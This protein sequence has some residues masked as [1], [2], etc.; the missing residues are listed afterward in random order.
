M[1]KEKYK[2]KCHAL[3]NQTISNFLQSEDFQLEISDQKNLVG[4]A[5]FD[6]VVQIPGGGRTKVISL[7]CNKGKP[8]NIFENL[9]SIPATPSNIL[10]Y[11]QEQNV[12]GF[13]AS[14]IDN[15]HLVSDLHIIRE[16]QKNTT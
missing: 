1:T 3:V 14:S 5:C 7:I 2:Q 6:M 11:F 16:H 4:E 12:P 13:I 15:K 8:I 9:K 10:T